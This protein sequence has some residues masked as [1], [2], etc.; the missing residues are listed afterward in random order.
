MC[1]IVFAWQ[2]HPHYR[3]VLAANRDELHSRPARDAHWWPDHKHVLAGRDLQAGGTWLAVSRRGRIATVTN[4]REMQ[5][6]TG[7]VKSR[8]EIVSSFVT[9]VTPPKDFASS[10]NAK[11]YSGY[12]LLAADSD[13]IAYGSNIAGEYSVLKAGI[14]GLSNAALDTPWHKLLR[15]REALRDLVRSDALS[16]PSLLRLLADRQPAPVDQ[17]DSSTLPFPMARSL[18]APFIVSPEY[19]TRCSTTILWSYS[20]ELEFC[21]RSFD[22][23]GKVTGT[24]RH[25]FSTEDV[26]KS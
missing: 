23:S 3:L 13:Q 17:I 19:G 24:A 21:E 7:R 8:G 2:A 11:N 22:A 25:R 16:E 14:Y 12:S 18:S 5:R 9:G 1:L 4:Y 10:L 26:K 15:S 20:G 6:S